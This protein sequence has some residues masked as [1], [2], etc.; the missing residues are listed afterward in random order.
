M[1]LSTETRIFTKLLELLQQHKLEDGELKGWWDEGEFKYGIVGYQPEITVSF[2]DNSHF[3][4]VFS[5]NETDGSDY[6]ISVPFDV[7]D[8]ELISL[9]EQSVRYIVNPE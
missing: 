7:D 3:D 1:N 6:S 2:D 5:P 8:S 9:I 4:L